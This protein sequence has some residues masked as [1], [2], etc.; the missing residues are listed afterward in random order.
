MLER[1]FGDY[2]G[3]MHWFLE[4]FS[5]LLLTIKQIH[6]K[7]KYK[8]MMTRNAFTKIIKFMALGS[9]VIVMGLSFKSIQKFI[10]ISSLP[11]N[12]K[13]INPLKLSKWTVS[14]KLSW[15]IMSPPRFRT[16]RPLGS[17][18][19]VLGGGGPK[20]MHWFFENLLHCSKYLADELST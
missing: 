9:G 2:L 19:F 12:I 4:N 13:Q 18:V 3:N 5:S 15:V 17:V 8:V 20:W 1:G 10:E 16:L 7:C 14:T 11:L 6:L